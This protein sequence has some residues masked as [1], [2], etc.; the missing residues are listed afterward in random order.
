MWCE[1]FVLD[2]QGLSSYTR[3]SEKQVYQPFSQYVVSRPP[4]YGGLNGGA[5]YNRLKNT[6]QDVLAQL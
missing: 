2:T 3:D 1:S 4:I 5:N 6:Y